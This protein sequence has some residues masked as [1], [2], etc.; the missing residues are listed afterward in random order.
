M[1]F[2]PPQSLTLE[3]FQEL[4]KATD[5][6]AGSET[7]L[8]VALLGLAGE[9][10]NLQTWYKKKLR[11][12]DAY[13]GFE[14]QTAE[15]LGD[16]LWYV[17]NIASRLNLSLGDIARDNLKKTRDRWLE[18]AEPPALYDEEW[19]EPQQLPRTF[20]YEYTTVRDGERTKVLLVDL[21]ANRRPVGDP[22]TDNA[23][24]DD[25]YR[26]HDV[27]H[28]AFAVHLGWSPVTRA[29]LKRKRKSDLQVDEVEDGARARVVE[30]AIAAAIFFYAEDHNFLDG[31]KALDWE[32]LRTVKRLT[33][34]F[35]VSDRSAAD[36][37]RAIFSGIQV[38]RD[39]NAAQGGRIRG[40]L[41]QRLLTVSAP[42]G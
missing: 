13:Q 42:E 1:T 20:N 8:L 30:E 33:A 2:R 10:G 14:L 21:D 36:W 39:V 22:L 37:E 38:W 18:S 16:I 31:A 23:Y 19:P 32:L 25:G 11:D 28:L 9:A 3:Q 27:L 41:R 35:E 15:E 4:A 7:G 17:A 29:L 34:N 40:D 6:H 5:R 12:G 24:I 26:Y